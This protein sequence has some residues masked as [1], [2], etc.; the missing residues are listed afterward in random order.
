MC[1]EALV[2][3]QD[4]L[5]AHERGGMVNERLPAKSHTARGDFGSATAGEAPYGFPIANGFARSRRKFAPNAGK[6]PENFF[7]VGRYGR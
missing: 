6:R 1:P 5:F 7:K 2:V 4:W 3:Q